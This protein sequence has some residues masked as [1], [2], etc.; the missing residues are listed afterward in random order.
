MTINKTKTREQK[1]RLTITLPHD[2]Y[3]ELEYRSSSQDVSIAWL[4]RKA[5]NQYIS[6]DIPL[7]TSHKEG[8]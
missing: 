8:K 3:S 5:L 7:P 6:S 2:V 4:I 1:H